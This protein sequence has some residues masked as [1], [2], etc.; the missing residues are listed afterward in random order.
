MTTASLPVLRRLT[1]RG[2]IALA[3]PKPLAVVGVQF[4]LFGEQLECV[5]DKGAPAKGF[6]IGKGQLKR[7]AAHVV[8]QQHQV[9]GVDQR[10]FGRA[11]E[12]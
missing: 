6:P 2:R 8:E 7:G 1:R 10:V 5:A 3:A 11:L 4:S 9:V 12:R